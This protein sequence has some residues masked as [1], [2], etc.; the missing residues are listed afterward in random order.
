MHEPLI[1][2]LHNFSRLKHLEQKQGHFDTETTIALISCY[3][4]S[5]ID[6]LVNSGQEEMAQRIKLETQ[7]IIN[8]LPRPSR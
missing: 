7:D 6:A 3:S 2:S 8:Q 1:S 5:M 4:T